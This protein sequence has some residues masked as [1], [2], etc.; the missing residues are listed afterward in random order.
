[1][2]V[3]NFKSELETELEK[4]FESRGIYFCE[5][6]EETLRKFL[7]RDT[8]VFAEHYSTDEQHE[9]LPPELERYLKQQSAGIENAMQEILKR[10]EPA[11]MGIICTGLFQMLNEGSASRSGFFKQRIAEINGFIVDYKPLVWNLNEIERAYAENAMAELIIVSKIAC[12]KYESALYVIHTDNK[13]SHLEP[14]EN[15]E[16]QFRP[17]EKYK[18]GQK[19]PAKKF[20]NDLIKLIGA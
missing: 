20:A 18:K 13:L 12:D 8:E 1:M 4:A 15:Y 7:E 2:G 6:K 5:V 19:L 14:G 17:F 3:N 16:K 9:F 10:F 11:F